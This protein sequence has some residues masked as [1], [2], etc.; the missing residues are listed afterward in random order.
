MYRVYK[1][2]LAMFLVVLMVMGGMSGVI[3]PS[4]GKAYAATADFAGGTGTASDPY[5][6]ATAD[7]LNEVRNHV[8]AD[9]FFELTADIDLSSYANWEPIG[10]TN[11]NIVHLF[12]VNM[13]GN[14]YT[15][16]NLKIDKQGYY[17]GLFG[18]IGGIMTNM[19]LKDIDVKGGT[20]VGGL[21]GFNLGTISN[22]YVTGSVEG[23]STAGGLV[24]FNS[25]T[26]SSSYAAGSVSGYRNMGGL[27]GYNGGTISKSYAT[28]GVSGFAYMGGLVSENEGTI[29]NSYATGSVSGDQFV[30]GLSGYDRLGIINNSYATG[31]VSG[32]RYVGGL[33]GYNNSYGVVVNYSF[34]DSSTT[35][36]SDTGNGTGKTTE[37]MQVP[38]TF[39]DWNFSED[40]YMLSGE[41]PKLWAFIALAPGTNAG[42][43]KLTGVTSG[44]E[45]KVNTGTYTSITDTSVDNIVVELGDMIYVRV[46]ETTNQQESTEQIRNVDAKN[47]KILPIPTG[48][49]YGVTAPITGATP[50]TAVTYSAEYTATVS[51]SPTATLFV[52]ETAY[53]AT[54]TITPKAGYTL[55]GVPANSFT[56][57]G[58][59]TT[60]EAD[61]GVVTAVFPATAALITTGV[62]AG[63]TA[64]V[65]GAKPVTTVTYSAEYTATLS[66]SPTTT[67]FAQG[68][69][70]TATITIT[71]KEGYTLTGVPANFFSVVGATTT[72][73]A[74]SGVV[75]AVFPTT[76]LISTGSTSTTPSNSNVTSTNGTLTLPVNQ[77]GEVSFEDAIKISIPVGAIN[78]EL[79]LTIKKVLDSQILFANNEI[80]LSPMYEITKNFAED[81]SKPVTMNFT[82]D[83][84]LMNSNQKAAVFYYDEVRKAWVEVA[85]G[86]IEGNH[87]LIEVNHL[88]KYAVLSVDKAT[89]LPVNEPV[90]DTPTEINFSDV[91]GHWAEASIKQALSIGMVKGYLDGTFQPNR[92]VTRAEFAVMLMKVL[93]TQDAGAQLTFTDTAKIGAWAQTAIAQAVRAGIITG[94]EDGGFRPNAEITRAEMA[95]ILAKAL[96]ESTEVKLTTSFADDKDIPAWAKASVDFVKQAGMVQGKGDNEFA[97]QDSATRAEAVTVLLKLLAQLNK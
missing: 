91:A 84:T 11:Q 93:K 1:K 41:Y 63:V 76:Q 38:N 16:T 61:S 46:K 22:S 30:G 83:P 49:I 82:F 3:G 72:N 43:T 59:I 92:T 10:T 37:E 39:S 67:L 55:T 90:T 75:T 80:L 28:G 9:I 50:V 29:S 57:A 35:G 62:I 2:G 65:T 86:K 56:V 8:D 68:T 66:W 6:I 74:N 88:G 85:G 81:F 79:I 7:Q 96:G 15:I 20:Y 95:V 64:P 53:T 60:N 12:V 40:W 51:W 18:A 14:G 36:Q 78:K 58:A 47:I 17:I 77:A 13:N 4:G 21:V 44:M 32:N 48:A 24:G 70:Y 19:N 69:A 27:V 34:Y 42:T 73:I 26:I 25:G 45:Y 52:P 33:L 97:P 87:I 89:G 71:P 23:D 31:S 94:Y 54:I 5:Q